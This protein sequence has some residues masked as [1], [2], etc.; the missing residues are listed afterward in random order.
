VVPG[1]DDGVL[2]CVDGLLAHVAPPPD[3]DEA[4]CAVG[5]HCMGNVTGFTGGEPALGVGAAFAGLHVTVALGSAELPQGPGLP[6][7][8][9]GWLLPGWEAGVDWLPAGWVAGWL[10]PLPWFGW[11][12]VGWDPGF[13]WPEPGGEL[14]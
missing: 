14:D 1:L 4:L 13:V 7:D 3:G 2:A 6:D 10:D 8:V 5:A 9:L 11:P 12:P